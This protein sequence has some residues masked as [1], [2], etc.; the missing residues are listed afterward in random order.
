[1]ANAT[2]TEPTPPSLVC[3]HTQHYPTK[4]A[5]CPRRMCLE[6]ELYT[7]RET[8]LRGT[9]LQYRHG[10]REPGTRAKQGKPHTKATC[11]AI[12]SLGSIEA[13]G[14]RAV[15]TQ[16]PVG[17]DRRSQDSRAWVPGQHPV[18]ARLLHAQRAWGEPTPTL[19]SASR[20]AQAHCPRGPPGTGRGPSSSPLTGHL[21]SSLNSFP[22]GRQLYQDPLLADPGLLV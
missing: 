12:L 4:A 5:M 6:G 21:L 8:S 14:C 10:A 11:G 22:G 19:S 17:V 18:H 13:E 20:T 3:A 9:Q 15:I 16:G 1:M 2:S 7:H